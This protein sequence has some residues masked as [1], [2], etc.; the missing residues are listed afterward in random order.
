VR[1]GEEIPQGGDVVDTAI[2]IDHQTRAAYR[3][4]VR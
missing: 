2:G 1:L 3:H 4:L